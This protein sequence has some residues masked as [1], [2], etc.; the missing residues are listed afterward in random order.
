MVK[1]NTER[2]IALS[3]SISLSSANALV[4]RDYS[5][6]QEVI[7]GLSRY[8]DLSF[9]IVLDKQ[10]KIVAH[11]DSSRLGLYLND[12]PKKAQPTLTTSTLAF[13][14]VITPIMFDNRLIGWVRISVSNDSL[15]IDIRNTQTVGLISAIIAIL[16]SLIFAILTGR[17]LTRRLH[18]IQQ[19]TDA[20]QSGQTTARIDL[21]GNDEAAL[22][23]K[24]INLMLDG[25]SEREAEIHQLAF[26]DSLTGLP[27][28]LSLL[29]KL[30]NALINC[31]KNATSGA[32]MFLDLD[33]FK[34][35]NDTLGHDVGDMLLQQVSNRLKH[36]TIEGSTAARLGGDEFVVMIEGLSCHISEAEQQ[37][38]ILVEKVFQRLSE[39][40]QLDGH[41]HNSTSSIGIALF[42]GQTRSREEVIK[43]ADIAMYQAK[44][45][46]RHGYRF[47]DQNMQ[48][49]LTAQTELE[50]DLS[51]AIERQQLEL[52]YQVQVNEHVQAIGA[53][54]LI[55]WHHPVHGMVPPC[56][57]I[58]LA[59]DTGQIIDIG[60]WVLLTACQQIQ[61]WKNDPKTAHLILAINV[62]AKQFFQADFV[63]QVEKIIADTQ[64]NPN[65][66]KLELT[67]SIFLDKLEE[68]IA[69]MN[70]LKKIGVRFSLDDFGTGYSSLQ[71]LK[72]LPLNQLKI[73][74]S[75][76]RDIT[77]DTSDKV[78]VRTII[79]MAKAL[80][81]NVIAEGVE[82]E[83]Q[84]EILL[85]ND[86]NTF[87][88]YL[89]SKPVPL[90]EFEALL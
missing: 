21:S 8:P 56:Q 83:E 68:I 77:S 14:D 44:K 23:A 10:G 78:I 86:C 25:L 35:L 43:Q 34:T 73:D 52:H 61:R 31:Q 26:Y 12:I 65:L 15:A 71:Y 45:E 47:F 20:V 58:P 7:K 63:A 85:R 2:A 51:R 57:F 16:V 40:Y 59:E 81:L 54:V 30:D 11:T 4:T 3:H 37:I 67:E 17:Y 18:A 42:D 53:E 80:N 84:R 38:I 19:V 27:N 46:G 9:A 48:D 36:C 41:E 64:I 90:I 29:K 89:F 87:Q 28:R 62:S 5:G 76:V 13:V 1:S 70:A 69:S 66:V 22:L 79:A 55:R 74:Q 60:N 82:T 88:G 24:Q 39:P 32:V 33:H 50:Q 72:Q 49:A 75:F 6:L